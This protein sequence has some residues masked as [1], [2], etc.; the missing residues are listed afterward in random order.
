MCF[1][2]KPANSSPNA[3][4]DLQKWVENPIRV[5]CG[6]RALFPG[7]CLSE[8]RYTSVRKEDKS[9]SDKW[10]D[11]GHHEGIPILGELGQMITGTEECTS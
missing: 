5:R 4:E 2:N 7:A 11:E 9:M 8:C 1:P 6:K 10:E 3:A